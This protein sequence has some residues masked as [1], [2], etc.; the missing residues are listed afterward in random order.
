MYEAPSETHRRV[1]RGSTGVN[2]G[3][4]IGQRVRRGLPGRG[5][6]CTEHF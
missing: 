6:G 2:G 5:G 4:A 1:N 3:S